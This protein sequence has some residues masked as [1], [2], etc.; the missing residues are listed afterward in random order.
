LDKT[1]NQDLTVLTAEQAA[2]VAGGLSYSPISPV[3][4]FCLTCTSGR[5]QM[6]Q[7]EVERAAKA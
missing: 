2:Q 7:N 3:G 4:E 6:F 5:L 1:S